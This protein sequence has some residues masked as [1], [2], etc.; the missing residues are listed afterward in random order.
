MSSPEFVIFDCD[1][2]LV[3]SEVIASRVD[4]KLLSSIG[5]DITPEEMS[6][7]FAGLT[8]K[9]ILLAVEAEA[10]IPIPASL[11]GDADK[12]IDRR[13]RREVKSIEGAAW[14]LQ[15]VGLPFA[16]CSNS[17][18]ERLDITL[19]ATG[20]K[21]LVPALY[22]AKDEDGVMEKPAPDIYLMAA[23]KAGAS[24]GRTFV[25]EDSTHGVHGAS[26]AGMRVIGFTGGSHTYLGHAD[27]LLEAGAET[28]IAKLRD[29]PATVEALGSF[30]RLG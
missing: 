5:Y 29:F 6:E 3:D 8:F 1:G 23:E 17:G 28:V 27:K 25:L 18:Y 2:V 13:L 21:P 24:P 30:G 11:L 7:R 26:R 10:N 14:L 22:S 12:E 9:D 15:S 16:I 4:A 19:T 20:L